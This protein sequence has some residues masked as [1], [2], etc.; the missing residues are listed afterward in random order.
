MKEEDGMITMENALAYIQWH[1]IESDGIIAC[2]ERGE[3][4]DQR[5]VQRMEVAF[6]ALEGA[7]KEQMLVPKHAVQIVRAASKTLP[8]LNRCMLLHPERKTEIS[9]L[10]MEVDKWIEA[11]FLS[12][13]SEE[14]AISLVCQH[15]LGTP[16]FNVQL[17]LGEID[18]NAVQE[19][20]SALDVLAQLWKDRT[21]I[22]KLAVYAMLSVPWLFTKT[23]ALFS[24]EEKQYLQRIEQ[25]LDE[26]ITVCLS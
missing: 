5:E 1:F 3:E 2:I 20:F 16:S 7:W 24:E 10:V 6:Q 22:S 8:R 26:Y 12:P 13:M 11:V 9:R 4:I 21:E 25:Q 19:L 17:Y 14:S 18:N 23:S 15:L